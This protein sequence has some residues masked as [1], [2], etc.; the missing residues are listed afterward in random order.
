MSNYGYNFYFNINGRVLTLPITPS[1]LNISVGAKNNVVSLISGGDVNILKSPS[2]VEITFDARFPMRKYPFSRDPLTFDE[3]HKAFTDAMVKKQPIIFTVVRTLPNGL[4]TWGTT[5][6]VALELFETKESVDDGDDVIVS[7]ELKEYKE[8]GVKTINLSSNQSSTS[9]SNKPRDTTGRNQGQKTYTVKSGDCLWLIAKNFYGD[10]SKYTKI[11]K[12]NETVIENTAR[13]YGKSS[14]Q[15][16][17]W[18]YPG[19]TL[20]IPE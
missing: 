4:G 14:S 12:A 17:H 6:K 13:K 18:I 15:N 19:T 9:T 16:G 1:E 11:Y 7:F 5:R 2:L 10:G 20:I 8:Y 3:Y